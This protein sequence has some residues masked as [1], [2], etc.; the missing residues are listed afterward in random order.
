ME[1]L[2]LPFYSSMPGVLG[3]PPFP[4]PPWC[5]VKG[6][7]GDVAW[8]SSHHMPDPSKSPSHDDGAHAVLVA[9]G[10]KMLAVILQHSEPY[11]KVESMQLEYSL[12]LVSVLY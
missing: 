2:K 8:F 3:S 10:K 12:S 9:A 6:R 11:S 1:S 4:L 7:A 5:P